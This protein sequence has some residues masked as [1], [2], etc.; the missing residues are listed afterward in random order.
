[1]EPGA[2]KDYTSGDIVNLIAVDCSKI[3][4]A[5]TF[6]NQIWAIPLQIGLAIYF[7]WQV[8]GVSVFVGKEHG[9]GFKHFVE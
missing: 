3:E 6:L 9:T 7:L 2:R 8:I 4:E 1:M 5:V